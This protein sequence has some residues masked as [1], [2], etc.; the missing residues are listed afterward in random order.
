MYGY[1]SPEDLKASIM[2]IE[3]QLYVDPPRRRE[4]VRQIQERGEVTAFESKVYRKDGTIMWISEHARAV[5]G[6]GGGVAYYEGTVEDITERKWAEESLHEITAKLQSLVQASPLAIIALDREGRVMSWNPAAE[7]IFG[8]CEREV[9]GR[10]VPIVPADQQQ[11]FRTMIAEEWQ[12]ADADEHGAKPGAQGRHDRRSQPVDRAATRRP[13]PDRG[14]AVPHGRH[15]RTKASG[16]AVPAGAE[17]GGDRPA[18]RRRRPRLQ[19]PAHRHPGLQRD[20]ARQAAAPAIRSH[21]MVEQIHKAG[22]RAAA[23][24]RQLLA[25]SRKQVLMPVVLD[26]NARRRRTWKSCCAG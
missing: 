1:D 3:R 17:D 24:T 7:H 23:L 14:H 8:W 25:F 9:L 15:H 5:R 21:E 26:L 10:P 18:G 19:Q 20:R 12:G 16:R 22:E 2:D 6:P 4:F 13:R 11:E